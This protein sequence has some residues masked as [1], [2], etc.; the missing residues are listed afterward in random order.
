MEKEILEKYLQEGLSLNKITEITG[1]SLTT[2][3]YWKDKYCL[4]SKYKSFMKLVKTEYGETRYC[5]RC[6]CN[7]KTDNFHQRR[8][9]ANSSTYCKKCTSN[10]TVERLRDLK[11]K[12]IEY[13]GGSCVKCGYDK[14]Q[15]ALEFHH[16]NPSEKD[17]NPS[18]L[19]KYSF[20]ERVKNEL[21]KCILVCSNC[22]R[23][24]HD[25]NAVRKWIKSYKLVK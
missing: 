20:D 23:E 22:H 12:M 11:S 17:F 9:R 14:C 10:Q 5:P 25:D 24:I 4:E 2:I 19:R 6:K 16:I 21:D 7:V 18:H 1:K 3:R 13:K 8:G 15:G